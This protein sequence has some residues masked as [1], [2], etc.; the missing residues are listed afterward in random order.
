LI[1][2]I[3]LLVGQGERLECFVGDLGFKLAYE[4]QETQ[5]TSSEEGI[6][7]NFNISQCFKQCK[8]IPFVGVVSTAF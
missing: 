3:S 1:E 5:A 6:E 8:N 2:V 7:F 4:V